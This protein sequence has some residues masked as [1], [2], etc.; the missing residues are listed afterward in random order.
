MEVVASQKR[1]REG[2]EDEADVG[3]REGWAKLQQMKMQRQFGRMMILEAKEGRFRGVQEQGIK[4][5]QGRVKPVA[6]VMATGTGNSVLFMLPGWAEPGRRTV[7]IVALT[8]LRQDMQRRLDHIIIN[9]CHV[10]L[11]M[12]SRFGP[13]WVSWA[14]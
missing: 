14:S 8:A 4:A 7:V 2:F 10:I 11:K 3:Q 5:I 12:V 13:R 6:T 9:E 1:N